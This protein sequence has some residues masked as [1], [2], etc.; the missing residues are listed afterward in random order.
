MNDVL[1]KILG[2][3]VEF[4]P[5]S[6]DFCAYLILNGFAPETISVPIDEAG[7]LL[8]A[9]EEQ[10]WSAEEDYGDFEAVA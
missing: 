2:D 6:T 10:G 4:T 3:V 7:H 8:H 1:Y 9:I 5:V